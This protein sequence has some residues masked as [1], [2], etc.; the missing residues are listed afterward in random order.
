MLPIILK[1]ISLVPTSVSIIEAT[2]ANVEAAETTEAKIHA[3]ADGAEKLASA[4]RA[5]L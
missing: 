5:T 1:L 2:I 4:I 3:I